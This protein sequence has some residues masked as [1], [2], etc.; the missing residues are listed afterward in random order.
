L[1]CIKQ[2]VVHVI[3]F[4]VVVYQEATTSVVLQEHGLGTNV[5]LKHPDRLVSSFVAKLKF[6]DAIVL[7]IREL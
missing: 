7:E 4:I 2:F 5:S 6:E 3:D 1:N